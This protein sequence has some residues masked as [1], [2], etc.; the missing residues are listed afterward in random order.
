MQKKTSNAIYIKE[1]LSFYLYVSLIINPY[2]IVKRY[3]KYKIHTT[4]H[5]Y[6]NNVICC[7]HIVYIYDI[8]IQKWK[9]K[10]KQY[11]NIMETSPLP[12][13]H[14]KTVRFPHAVVGMWKTPQIQNQ[15]GV[16]SLDRSMCSQHLCFPKRRPK[17]R[18]H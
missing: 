2:N 8:V 5:I 13:V 10:W 3:S 14:S 18:F 17:L 1:C 12:G 9:Q 7:V 15:K 4:S 16:S 11:G 6:S